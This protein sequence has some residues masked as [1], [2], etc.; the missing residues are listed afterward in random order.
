MFFPR[1]GRFAETALAAGGRRPAHQRRDASVRHGGCIRR[2]IV[3]QP[4][5]LPRRCLIGRRVRGIGAVAAL[6]GM[7]V[8]T[9][10]GADAAPVDQISHEDS[11]AQYAIDRTWLY[12]DDAR[13]AA[14]GILVAGSSLSYTDVGGDPTRLTSAGPGGGSACVGSSG[15]RGPCY[16]A[17]A[18]NVAQPGAMLA[19]DAEMG[20]LA[21]LSV[22]GSIGMGLGDAIAGPTVGGMAG[23][24]F[25]ALPSS[26][27]HTRLVLSGGYL[28]EAWDGPIY[29]AGRS[30]P[31][32]LPGAPH[33]DNG[34]WFMAAF[35]GDVQRLRLAA[36]ALGEHVFSSGRDPLDVRVD[37]GASYRI[38]GDFR[39][40]AEYVGQDLEETFSA[41]AEGG[42]RHF[43]GPTASLQL[44]HERVTVVG[45]P[46]IGLSS[47]SPEFVARVAGSVGF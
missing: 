42:A 23:L 12:A 16:A 5:G 45:G 47:Q 29:D 18:G 35:S 30:L 8:A 33:G 26:W 28:R 9:S 7:Q 34:A 13:V 43:V 22:S 36:T 17:F 2:G 4:G 39:L 1:H 14:P 19:F 15:L 44:L 20:L 37:L 24:R 40:G 10:A 41:A 11:A 31:V 46:S 38:A 25:M 3:K 27:T 32:W 21:R 6:A